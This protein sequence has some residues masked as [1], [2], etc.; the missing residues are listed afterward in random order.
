M[1]TLMLF[2]C[3]ALTS[4]SVEAKEFVV[5]QETVYEHIFYFSENSAKLNKG[6]L[7]KL[8]S[9]KTEDFSGSVQITGRTNS[10]AS[11][12]YNNRLS[13]RRATAVFNYLD[14]PNATIVGLGESEATGDM[15][16]DRNV[17]IQIISS[18][19]VYQPIFGGYNMV[20]GPVQHLQWNTIPK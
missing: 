19:L 14:V 17:T 3:M 11:E 9:I 15:D 12:A 7:A 13:M 6:A 20:L 1:R 8:K 2:V 16:K 5:E 4:L 10:R 18:D